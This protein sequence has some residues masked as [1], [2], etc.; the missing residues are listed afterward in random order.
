MWI[1]I[2]INMAVS[3][4][5]RVCVFPSSVQQADVLVHVYREAVT[6]TGLDV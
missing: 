5:V 3:V 6:K 2:E 1:D 4:C